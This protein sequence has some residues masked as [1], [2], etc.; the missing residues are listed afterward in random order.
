MSDGLLEGTRAN[1]ETLI[2]KVEKSDHSTA[3]EPRHPSI[4][5]DPPYAVWGTNFDMV[6]NGPKSLE[7]SWLGCNFFHRKCSS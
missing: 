3:K 5:R 1:A 7:K 6:K 4:F 2:K